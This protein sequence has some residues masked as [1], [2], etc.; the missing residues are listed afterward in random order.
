MDKELKV[1]D[2]PQA[3]DTKAHISEDGDQNVL[4]TDKYHPLIMMKHWNLGTHT[5]IKLG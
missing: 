3:P 5:K 2:P 4:I 1:E